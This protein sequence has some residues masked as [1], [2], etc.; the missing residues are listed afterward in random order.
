MEDERGRAA[1]RAWAPG[2]PPP[3]RP[4]P[5]PLALARVEGVALLWLAVAAA[6]LPLPAA[7]AICPS[8]CA[9]DDEVLRATCESAGLEVVPIQLNPEVRSISLRGNRIVSLH[10]SFTFY[11]NLRWLDVSRNRVASLGARVFEFQ[12]KLVHLNISGN[13]VSTLSKDAF[14]GLRSLRVLDLSENLLEALPAA[15]LVDTPDLAE[16]YLAS[17]RLLSVADRAFERLGQ[18]RVLRLD[19]NQ[20]L[21]VPSGALRRLPALKLLG[22]SDNLLEALEEEAL[23][24]LRDLRALHLRGNVIMRVHRAA[25]DGLPA[26]QTLDLSDNNLTSVPTAALAKLARLADLD[27][28]GNALPALEPVAFQSLFELRRLRLSRL[29]RLRRVDARALADNVRLESVQLDDTG[30]DSLPARLFHDRRALVHISVRGNGF[31]S[32]DSSQ[33][34]LDQLRS[35][36]LGDNPLHCNCSLL[37]LWLLTRRQLEVEARNASAEA[38]ATA[39]AGG[40]GGG[41]SGGA[42]AGDAGGAATPHL[43]VDA[44]RCAEPEPLRYKLVAEAPEAAV[45]CDASW[46]SVIIVAVVVLALFAGTCGLLLLVGSGR[47]C[48]RPG[49]DE[50]EASAALPAAAAAHGHL[51]NGAVLMLVTSKENADPMEG[52]VLRAKDHHP[53]PVTFLHHPHHRFPPDAWD[54]PCKETPADAH[55][56]AAANVD[57]PP[58]H[59]NGAAPRKPHIVYV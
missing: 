45:R 3:P 16:L 1:A 15:A 54:P 31:T 12:E 13:E 24:A 48:R 39:A 56:P 52:V 26:L 43:D 35:L 10:M 20:L 9:C 44:I 22:L 29:P 36:A 50:A 51:Q 49:E 32:L 27:L 40:A 41:G 7:R 19:D 25:F 6:C 59:L 46:L 57:P 5:R 23:P 8:K 14:R 11:M 58:Y 2:R 47:W 18:L 21:E 4:R 53:P 42:G 28:S 30:L 37:W 38:A 33:F 55:A 17:N 34:P